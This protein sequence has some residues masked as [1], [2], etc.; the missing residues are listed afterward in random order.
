M[1]KPSKKRNQKVKKILYAIVLGIIGLLVVLIA[2][3]ALTGSK[4]DAEAPVP[5]ASPVATVTATAAP[6]A[7]PTATPTVTPTVT[8]T[9]TPT[10]TPTVT[11][12]PEPTATPTATPR[13]T[14]T[15]APLVTPTPVP[16]PTPVPPE[17]RDLSIQTPYLELNL[18]DTTGKL[19]YDQ[20]V[21]GDVH[22][23]SFYMQH[24]EQSIPLYRLIMGDAGTGEWLGRL[25]DDTM[26]VPLTYLAYTIREEELAETYGTLMELFSKILNDVSADPRFIPEKSLTVGADQGVTLAHWNLELPSD[27]TWEETTGDNSYTAVFYATIRGQ[28]IPLYRVQI[29]EETVQTVLG[30]YMLNGQA[31]PL[32][33]ETYS[34]PEDA[35]WTE[36]DTSLAYHLMNTINELIPAIMSSE[37]FVIAD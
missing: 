34:L 16:S 21:N 22:T 3:L 36:E 5:T 27:I 12:T 26:D 6:T 24:G 1:T 11:P 15:P 9:A 13:V 18:T 30:Q 29:G 23:V 14:N 25:V 33:V 37:G 19:T 17:P 8:P 20:T 7:T 35:G 32:S 28:S 2:V 4:Q 31:L 10:A